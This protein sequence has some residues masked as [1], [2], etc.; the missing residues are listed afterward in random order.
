[1]LNPTDSSFWKVLILDSSTVNVLS[2][3]LRINDLRDCSVTSHF[4]IENKREKITEI[5]AIY[6][7]QPTKSNIERIT[8]DV[9]ANLYHGYYINFTSRIA[10]EDLES[11][12]QELSYKKLAFH[13]VSVYDQFI[14]FVAHQNNLFS[15]E[16][17]KNIIVNDTNA[18]IDSLY[19]VFYCLNQVP[20]IVSFDKKYEILSKKLANKFKSTGLIQNTSKRPL[21]IILNRDF[22]VFSPIEHVWSYNAIIHDLLGIN[23]NKIEFD[24]KSY[25]II[26]D[27]YLK[28]QHE[29]FPV[30]AERI[31]EELL[32][33]KKEM[34]THNIGNLEQTNSSK[35]D[36][37]LE[38]LPELAQRNDIIQTHMAICLKIVEI[39]KER[40]IDEFYRLERGRVSKEDYVSISDKGTDSDITRFCACL[41]DKE[42]AKALMMKR[43]LNTK[44]LKKLEMHA[45]KV[46]TVSTGY[47]K[48]AN[49]IIGNVKKLLTGKSII[50]KEIERILGCI[51]SQNLSELC[52]TDFNDQQTLYE[53]EID[54]IVVF[55]DGYGTYEEYNELQEYGTKN[56]MK[57]YFGCKKIVRGEEYVEELAKNV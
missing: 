11:L 5:P 18:C 52:F 16:H 25:E 55:I 21:L 33:H 26:D 1:M 23:L 47:A 44:I 39:V 20:F 40:S 15:I 31:E 3:I 13:I 42:I 48:F 38:K 51:K 53:K 46:E 4:L 43:K 45:N 7:V 24:G 9:A 30:V 54:S 32:K 27:F 36:K 28:N 17:T 14:D 50:V 34:A 41:K 2:P 37:V 56:G 12:A 35:I 22:D 8:K 29:P 49:N 19:S 57:V 6:F 10:R